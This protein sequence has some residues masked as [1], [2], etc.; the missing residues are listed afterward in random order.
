MSLLKSEIKSRRA[1]ELLPHRR[2]K[3]DW[4][5]CPPL[6]RAAG[7]ADCWLH[8]PITGLVT[9]PYILS[10]FVRRA[11]I[12]QSHIPR[13]KDGSKVIPTTFSGH[14]A[15]NTGYLV[16][17][18]IFILYCCNKAV[19]PSRVFAYSDVGGEPPGTESDITDVYSEHWLLIILEPI[20]SDS[21]ISKEL[22]QHRV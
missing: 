3:L 2:L 18:I 22:L 13:R 10:M 15:Y 21:T 4:V 12:G 1:E 20:S 6:H 9:F 11:P 17:L 7:T 8:G 19:S 14:T 5:R 16:T